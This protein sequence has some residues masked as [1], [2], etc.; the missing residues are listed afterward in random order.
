MAEKI[1]ASHQGVSVQIEFDDNVYRPGSLT[2]ALCDIMGIKKGSRVIDVGCGTGYLGIV[3]SLLGAADVVCIDTAAGAVA[4]TEH[5][6]RINHVANLKAVRGS[7]LDPVMGQTADV[8]IS[9]PPQMPFPSNFS[10]WRYGGCDGTDVI[11]KIIRQASSIL[12]PGGILYLVHA[13]IADPHK[14]R[15]V[16]SEEKFKW[17]IVSTMEKELCRDIMENLAC[18]LTDYLL[19]CM[20]R[21]TAE[22]VEREN[23]YYYPVWFYRAEK[24]V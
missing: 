17:Q 1:V 15:K 11:I 6:A 20:Q 10:P 18:G 2:E 12:P 24:Q 16:L 5:N 21:G 4:W 22:M 3:A 13:G 8:I 23:R 9:L 7:A 19:G 14:T